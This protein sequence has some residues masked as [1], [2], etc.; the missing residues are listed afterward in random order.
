M[1]RQARECLLLRLGARIERSLEAAGMNMR[2]NH[3]HRPTPRG[4]MLTT[5]QLRRGALHNL[6]TRYTTKLRRLIRSRFT[7]S[8]ILTSMMRLYDAGILSSKS[9]SNHSR[10][11]KDST[12]CSL[13]EWKSADFPNL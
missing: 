6:I 9:N 7:L 1:L 13:T 8:P 2:L 3:Q 5:M 10:A 12:L 4:C 11:P